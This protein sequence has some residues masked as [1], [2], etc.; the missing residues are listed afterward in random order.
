MFFP[1]SFSEFKKM[2]QE[3]IDTI[4][5]SNENP[6]IRDLVIIENNKNQ[7]EHTDD[8]AQEDSSGNQ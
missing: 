3:R 2:M 1:L 7:I 8:K 5:Y 6:D 4:F